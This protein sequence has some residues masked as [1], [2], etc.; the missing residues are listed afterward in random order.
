MQKNMKF[1]TEKEV[2]NKQWKTRR[3]KWKQDDVFKT[4]M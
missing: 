3:S 4:K 1:K 2:D